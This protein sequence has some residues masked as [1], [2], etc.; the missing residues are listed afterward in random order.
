MLIN[1]IFYNVSQNSDEWQSLRCGKLTASMFSD[2]FMDKKTKGYQDIITKVAFEKVTGKQQKNF[3]GKWLD[4]GHET[5]PEA[6]ENYEIETFN[7]LE[8]GGIWVINEYVAA[9]PDAKIVGQ[10]AGTEFKCP[11]I[12]TYREYL[13][14]KEKKGIVEL[15]KSYLYQVHG[16][17]LCT[18]WD[19]VDYMPYYD[20]SLKQLLTRVYRDESILKEI[21]YKIEDAIIDIDNLIIKIKR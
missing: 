4:Y 8:N 14:S 10:N 5:E 13:D 1:P 15:P 11:A 19:Y 7:S 9:S 17:M 18:G 3:S 6:A 2:L 16:Q 21:V 20:H 12:S